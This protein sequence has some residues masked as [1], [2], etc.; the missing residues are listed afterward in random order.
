MVKNNTQDTLDQDTNDENE[1][2]P[3][4]SK[5]NFNQGSL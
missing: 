2:T 3:V 1:E 5:V 4:Q